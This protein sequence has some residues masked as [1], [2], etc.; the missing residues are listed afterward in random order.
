MAQTRFT[1]TLISVF[2]ALAL[3]LAAI[4]LY[5]V[6]SYSLRQRVQEFGVRMAFGAGERN[7]VGLVV[8]HGMLL[9]L[10]GIGLGLVAAFVL[11]RTASSLLFGVTPMDPLTFGG[12]PVLLASVTSLASYIPARRATRIDPVDALRGGSR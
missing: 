9:A 11:T 10:A 4:G 2:A 12:I 3:V 6:I 5:G 1:L 7:I 8:G